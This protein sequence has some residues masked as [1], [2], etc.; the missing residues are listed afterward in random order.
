MRN[1][2]NDEGMTKRVELR[3]STL[4]FISSLTAIIAV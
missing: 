3:P 4:G 2:E 1:L